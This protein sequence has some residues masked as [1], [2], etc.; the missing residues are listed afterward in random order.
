MLGIFITRK[1]QIKTTVRYPTYLLEWL[2]VEPKK[3]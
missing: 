3:I 1:M 2:K